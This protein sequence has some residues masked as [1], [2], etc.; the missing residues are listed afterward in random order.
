[1]RKLLMASLLLLTLLMPGTA[2]AGPVGPIA[3][4]AGID[5]TGLIDVTNDLNAFFASLP[6]GATVVFPPTA[7]YRAEGTVRLVDRIGLLLLG[8]GASLVATTD[9]SGVAPY[10]GKTDVWPRHRAHLRIERGQDITV[11]GLKVRGPNTSVAY[12]AALEAQHGFSVSNARNVLLENVT[13]TDVWGDFVAVTDASLR[14]TVRGGVFSGAGRQGFSVDQGEDIAFEAFSMTRVA[15][16]AVDIEPQLAWAVR[17]VTVRN[18]HFVA[19]ITNRIFANLGT[20]AVVEDV[21]FE[22]NLVSGLNWSAVSGTSEGQRSRYRFTNNRSETATN[23][24]P[25]YR[26]GGVTHVLVEGAHQTFTGKDVGTPIE[27]LA[28]TCGEVRGNRF[29]GASSV[30]TGVVACSGGLQKPAAAAVATGAGR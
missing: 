18:G 1:M 28:G 3:V 17:R 11:R 12:S 27:F 4:P 8:N 9:G 14:V 24:A 22:G 30:S 13:A 6:R 19:P 7:T 5:P 23:H 21:I 20:G 29:P 10:D 15:R 16:S 26:I 2:S 25:A